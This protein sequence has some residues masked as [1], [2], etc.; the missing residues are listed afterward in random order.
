MNRP[1]FWLGI[2][3]ESCKTTFSKEILEDGHEQH[4]PASYYTFLQGSDHMH[5]HALLPA[6][7]A[8]SGGAEKAILWMKTTGPVLHFL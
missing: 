3:Q 2:L 1:L 8:R 4:G 7:K 5:Q 6:K